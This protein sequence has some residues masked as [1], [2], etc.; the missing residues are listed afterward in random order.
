[1]L[2]QLFYGD[3]DGELAIFNCKH[4]GRTSFQCSGNQDRSVHSN[5]MTVPRNM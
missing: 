5:S 4:C 2:L 3:T 1:M